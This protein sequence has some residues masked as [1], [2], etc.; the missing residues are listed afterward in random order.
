MGFISE[1][2]AP[3]PSPEGLILK[4][5][6]AALATGYGGDPNLVTPVR[7]W[8][9]TL[10]GR[11]RSVL[12]LLADIILPG[13]GPS[14][15]PSTLN[16]ADFFDEWLSA[17]YPTQQKDRTTLLGGIVELDRLSVAAFGAP[18]NTLSARRR[19]AMVARLSNATGDLQVF[20][21]RL[22]YLVIGGYFTSD[23]GMWAVGYRGNVPLSA[24][25][26]LGEDA[27]LVIDQQLALLGLER[28]P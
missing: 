13:A 2:L 17:P 5:K 21:V 14:D 20:F 10:S 27:L 6:R 22:R 12:T 8:P 19:R 26:P 9:L 28:D 1:E 11:Q 23:V 3:A 4:A 24:F 18:F 16:I 15:A 25:P 7:P